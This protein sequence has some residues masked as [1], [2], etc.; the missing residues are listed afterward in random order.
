[1]FV[2]NIIINIY[3][4]IYIQ[5]TIIYY[6]L[7]LLVTL[8]T[9]IYVFLKSYIYDRLTSQGHITDL[10]FL[11]SE[12]SKMYIL[13]YVLCPGSITIYTRKLVRFISLHFEV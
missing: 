4:G 11:F 10:H 8:Y 2:I 7:Y 6:I 5:F 1:M 12:I 3:M 9:H 13:H